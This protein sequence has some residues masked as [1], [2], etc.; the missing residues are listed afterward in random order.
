M[1]QPII[2]PTGL[3]GQHI[4]GFFHHTEKAP[5]PGS[6]TTYRTRIGLGETATDGTGENPFLYSGNCL[7][8]VLVIALL[9]LYQVICES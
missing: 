2:C 8:E 5:V 9:G 4:L 6:I 1:I 7:A 3:D